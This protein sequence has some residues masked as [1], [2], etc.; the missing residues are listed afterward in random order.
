[1]YQKSQCRATVT[2][3]DQIVVNSKM[4]EYTCGGNI[5]KAFA[6]EAVGQMK[7]R[8]TED[9]QSTSLAIASQT[10]IYLGTFSCRYQIDVL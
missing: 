2:T 8:V 5:S 10:V 7:Q 1:M 6:R 9:G 4:P 3:K